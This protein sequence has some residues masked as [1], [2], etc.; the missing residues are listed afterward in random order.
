MKFSAI[1]VLMF[2]VVS[3]VL[4][5]IEFRYTEAVRDVPWTAVWSAVVALV[6]LGR[7]WNMV[8][9]QAGDKETEQSGCP[10]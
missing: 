6:L 5:G 4:A 7:T 2:C 8:C 10:G 3:I 1:A 9:D